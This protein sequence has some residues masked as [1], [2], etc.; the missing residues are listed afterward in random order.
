MQIGH[1]RLIKC[2]LTERSQKIVFDGVFRQTKKCHFL[3]SFIFLLFI[4]DFKTNIDSLMRLFADDCLV[5][6]AATEQDSDCLQ[7]QEHIFP[8]FATGKTHGR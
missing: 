6:R 8:C 7:L 1:T 3:A 4:D 2:F 5:H